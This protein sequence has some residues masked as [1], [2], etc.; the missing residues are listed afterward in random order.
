M[1]TQCLRVGVDVRQIEMQTEG[2]NT[3]YMVGLID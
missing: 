3:G 1:H 2:D